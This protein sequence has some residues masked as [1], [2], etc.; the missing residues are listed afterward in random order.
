MALGIHRH[1]ANRK[2]HHHERK[3][4]GRM[5]TD[6]AYHHQVGHKSQPSIKECEHQQRYYSHGNH[7]EKLWRKAYDEKGYRGHQSG[8]QHDE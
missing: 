1:Q 2:A 7:V 4:I 6:A 3:A 5:E 8:Q